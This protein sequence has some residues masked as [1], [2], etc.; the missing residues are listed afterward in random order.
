[1]H[2]ATTKSL[3]WGHLKSGFS[4]IFLNLFLKFQF[5]IRQASHYFTNVFSVATA[6]DTKFLRWWMAA[7]FSGS[8]WALEVRRKVI[9]VVPI[10]TWVLLPHLHVIVLEKLTINSNLL[11]TIS[12][13]EIDRQSLPSLVWWFQHGADPGIPCTLIS[14]PTIIQKG[15]GK[16]IH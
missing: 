11:S 1:M 14:Y 16:L 2:V 10:L 6:Q 7:T 15:S 4:N 13:F 9:Y 5:N 3:F 12:K 8:D